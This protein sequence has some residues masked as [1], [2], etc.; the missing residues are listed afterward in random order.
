MTVANSYAAFQRVRKPD[1]SYDVIYPIS[2]SDEVYV[3]I[4]AK[5]TLTSKINSMDSTIT[6]N[7][8]SIVEDV[9]TILASLP[10]FFNRPLLLNHVYVDD[11]SNSVST[12]LVT[13]GNANKG[14][15]FI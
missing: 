8:E 11:F 2:T 6:L 7:N 5:L 1:G 10:A 14:K 3:D 15:L 9:M 4:S 12:M 13:K